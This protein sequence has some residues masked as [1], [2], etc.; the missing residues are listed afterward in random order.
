[1]ASATKMYYNEKQMREWLLEYQRTAVMMDGI[2]IHKDEKLERKITVEVLKIVE[3][4]INQYRYA[5][6]EDRED[7][8]QEGIKACFSNFMKFNPEKGSSFNLFSIIVKIH[9]LN[10]TDRRKRHRNLADVDE[11]LEVPCNEETNYTLF[12]NNLETT[13]FKVIDENWVG[14]RRKRY[15]KI[16]AIILD[17]LRKTQKFV[18]RSDLYAWARSWG[19][20]SSL[21]REYIK[22]VGVFLPELQSVAQ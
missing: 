17:Y 18:S 12:F 9:L 11:C 6:F 5:I 21:V 19:V 14:T 15:T 13:L 1:M 2:V 8:R 16:S 3:A 10:Y 4:I 22:E 20:K 7:L